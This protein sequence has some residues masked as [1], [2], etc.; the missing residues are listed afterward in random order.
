MTEQL[1]EKHEQFTATPEVEEK[2]PQKAEQMSPTEELAPVAELSKNAEEIAVAGHE[3]PTHEQSSG[4]DT[5][6][7]VSKELHDLTWNRALT[8]IRKR[9]PLPEKALSKAIH[10]P[11]VDAVSRVGAKTVARPSGVL[12]GGI[13]AFAGSTFFLYMAKHY[14][15]A[16]NYLMFALFFVGGF[17]I[18]LILELLMTVLR[19]K[20]A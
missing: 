12:T 14:G 10:Q 3:L 4:G 8:R 9:L 2:A 18:G 16:Y 7:L 15:F 5:S 13:C 20:K 19:R 11:V 6:T 17:V 1:H